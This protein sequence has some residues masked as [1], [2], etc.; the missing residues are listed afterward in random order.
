MEKIISIRNTVLEIDLSS[1]KYTAVPISGKMR[2]LY[3]GGK[4]LGLKLLHD[5]LKPGIDPLDEQNIIIIMTGVVTG[6]SAPCSGRFHAVFKSPLTG[7]IGSSSCGG[8]FGRFLKTNG[9]DGLILKGQSE[10]PVN[11]HIDNDHVDFKDASKMW[12]KDIPDVSSMKDMAKKESLII[13][14]AGENRVRFANVASGHRFLGRGGLGAVFG[15]KNIKVITTAKGKYRVVPKFK[16][17]FKKNNSRANKYLNRNDVSLN[18]RQFGTGFFTKTAI[19][20]NMLPVHNF[21]Y[22]NHVDANQLSG[23]TIKKEYNTK[24]HTCKPCSILCGHK[25]TFNGKQ[26]S[27]PEHETIALLGASLGIFDPNDIARFND[28]CNQKGMDTI[29]AGGTLAW[30][31]EAT[32]EGLVQS[33]LSFGDAKE[34]VKALNDISNLNGLGSHMAMGSRHLSQKF[35]GK[36]FA[37]QVKGLE[38]AGYD[39]RGAYGQGLGYAV[40]NKGGCHLSSYPVGFENVL[41]L[42]KPDTVQAKPEF[43]KFL[44]NINCA[45]NSLVVCQ[46]TE[47]GMILETPIIKFT[48]KFI[49]KLLMHHLPSLAIALVDFSIYPKL[50]TAASGIKMTPKEFITAGE[51]IHVLERIMNMNEGIKKED[52]TLPDRLLSQPQMDDPKKRMVPLGSMIKKYYKIRDFDT[53]GKPSKTLLK[54]LG[55]TF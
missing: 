39:P 43:V 6:T 16:E 15:S 14:P 33:D 3:L 12:G 5:Q 26:T 18:L 41:S 38:I 22:G 8:S 49:L 34:I 40:A 44:E 48:P 45:I 31:M 28:I 51:R 53:N 50:F 54:R 10:K 30:V 1:Q 42:L 35:G 29:S 25:G 24:H 20:N 2:K 9:W 11:I 4:G 21:K 13:G 37:I 17:E 52:D 19:K 27:V 36:D 7:I 47:F 55:L 32:S 46:F 23:E